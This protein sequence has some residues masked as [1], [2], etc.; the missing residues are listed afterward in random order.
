MKLRTG[1]WVAVSF[2]ISAAAFAQEPRRDGRWEMTVTIELAGMPQALP[3]TTV[4]Q[5]ITKEQ[6]ADPEKSLFQPPQQGGPQNDCKVSDY[7]TTANKVTYT[8]KCTTPQEVTGE[9]EIAY[10]QNTMDAVMKLT[11]SA[12]GKTMA[13]TMKMAG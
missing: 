7:K 6:A 11:T 3:P 4:T 1:L 8:M 12:S 2:A 10:G 13:M 5:C 9:A